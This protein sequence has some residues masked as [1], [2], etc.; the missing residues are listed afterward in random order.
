MIRHR[1]TTPD[2]KI[3]GSALGAV[4]LLVWLVLWYVQD[5]YER[6]LLAAGQCD[7]IMEALYTPPPRATTWCSDDGTSCR[8]HYYQAD[9][10]MRSLWRCVDPG[11]D[12]ARVEFWRRTSEEAK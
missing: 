11:R 3:L 12:G 7:K 4:I 8:T 5:R 9:P 10:Y 6:R 2:S 1:R